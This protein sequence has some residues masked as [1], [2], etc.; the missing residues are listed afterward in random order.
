MDYN[1][2]RI[3]Y[4]FKFIFH[5]FRSIK[6][7]EIYFYIIQL[8]VGYTIILIP[9]LY[10]LII[11]FPKINK[12]SKWIQENK[13]IFFLVFLL[14]DTVLI[15]IISINNIDVDTIL[16]NEEK[17]FNKCKYNNIFGLILSLICYVI[18]LIAML[19][20]SYIEWYRKTYCCVVRINAFLIYVNT[21]AVL[22][23]IIFYFISINNYIIYF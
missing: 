2:I 12:K 1:N 6:Q 4:Y 11:D 17:N 9:F 18:I 5:H 13:Y 19:Q 3:D 14:I 23:S 22:L 7:N 15:S 10:K 21:L 20:F 8:V 16:L